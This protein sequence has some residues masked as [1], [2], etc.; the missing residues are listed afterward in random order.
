M[1][2]PNDPT[3]PIVG[4]MQTFLQDMGMPTETPRLQPL[5]GDGSKRLFWRFSSLETDPTFIAVE[6]VPTDDISKG[7]NLA[8]LTIGRHLFK[9]GLPIPYIYRYCLEK[10]WFILEDM[11]DQNLQDRSSD[12]NNRIPIYEKVVEILFRLQ[13]E[14]SDGFKGKWCYQTGRYNESVMRRYESNYF[15]DAFLSNYL[16]LQRDWSDLEGSFSHLAETASK[17]DSQFFLH[18]DFQSRNIQISDDKIGILDWQAGRLGPL[19]YDLASLLIDPY[20]DLSK[21]EKEQILQHYLWLLKDY[22]ATWIDPF[23]RYFPYLAVQRNLQ[24]LG[25]FS[26][27]TK[28]RG[29]LYFEAYIPPALKSLC[30]LLD[31]LRDPVLTPLKDLLRSLGD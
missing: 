17:A 15:R 10:G 3:I 28:V 24:I 30:G 12:L 31:E 29:K 8:Y 13:I 14:G 6:N 22:Q 19:P 2:D 11:G 26:F 9:K 20:T 18:R 5:A 7:E 16:G 4:F 25:A 27:L 23:V 21:Y 1:N